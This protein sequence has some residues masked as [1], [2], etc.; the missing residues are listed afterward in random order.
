MAQP[1]TPAPT[2]ATSKIMSG[3][4]AL[5]RRLV[6]PASADAVA[7]TALHGRLRRNMMRAA[8]ADRRHRRGKT[9]LVKFAE[10]ESYDALGLADLVRRKEVKPDEL[11]DEALARCERVNPKINAVVNAVPEKA[12]ALIA[13]GL[14]DGPFAGVPFLLKDLGCEAV[15]YPTHMGSRLYANYQW[16]FDSEIYLRMRRSGLVAFGR[17][18]SPELGVSP[19]TEAVVYGGPT[20]NPWNLERTS[21]GSSG[22]S[23]AAVAAGIVPMAHGSDGGGSIRIP[24]ACC[25]LFGLK[26]TRARLPDG[27]AVGEGWGGM[28]I[29]GFLSRSVRDTAAALDACQGAD[30]G[31]PYWAPPV[32]RPYMEEIKSPPKRLRVALCRTTYTGEPIHA[33]CAAAVDSAAKL[34]AGLGHQIVEAKPSFDFEKVTRAW[35][36]V[37]ACGTALSVKLRT[38]ALG[39]PPGKDD[40]EPAILDACAVAKSIAGADYLAAVNLV[41]ATGRLFARFMQDYDIFLSATLAEPPAKVGRFAMSNPDF[42]DYRLGPKGTIRYSP[43]TSLFNISGQ[44][45]ASIPLHWSKDGLPIGVHVAARFGDEPTLLKLAAQLEQARPWFDK[46]PSLPR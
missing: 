12:R 35:T 46:R 6:E 28:A 23:G 29:D 32:A 9:E 22:G 34:C 38:Q 45:A 27:P 18:T 40:L 30:L 7:V 4:L 11:L 14:P 41:H 25:G 37:V 16:T 31:A 24:A 1:T 26:P 17:T 15:G 3:V 8:A 21:G 36:D 13:A 33:D 5:P 10:Y 42:L 44:P 20:R 39:R 43:F 19:V 2:M